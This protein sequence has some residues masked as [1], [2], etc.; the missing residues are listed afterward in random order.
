[1]IV[2][3]AQQTLA[4]VICADADLG[5]VRITARIHDNL[6]SGI[7]IH[8]VDVGAV[9]HDEG[10][11][12]NSHSRAHLQQLAQRPDEVGAFARRCLNRGYAVEQEATARAALHIILGREPRP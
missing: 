8:V 3:A 12:F 6:S 7:T 2:Q 5:G 1:L 9:K 11:P 10:R 4:T